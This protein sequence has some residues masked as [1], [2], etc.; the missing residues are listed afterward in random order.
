MQDSNNKVS[1][2]LP[3]CNKFIKLEV[4]QYWYDSDGKQVPKSGCR[5]TLYR[6]NCKEKVLYMH[7]T[8]FCAGALSWTCTNKHIVNRSALGYFA[9]YVP[10]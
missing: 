4:T 3:K 6:K 5:Y 1:T 10:N 9:G 8:W 7:R 2:I